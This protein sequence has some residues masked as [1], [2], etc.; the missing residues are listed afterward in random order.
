MFQQNRN[1]ITLSFTETVQSCS[2]KGGL[3]G[4]REKVHD[5][6]SLKST[7]RLFADCLTYRIIKS[8]EDRRALEQDLVWTYTEIGRSMANAIQPGQMRCSTDN[9]KNSI[10]VQVCHS[11]IGIEERQLRQ[12]SG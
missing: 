5:T 7:T 11:R 12:V 2:K 6:A 9:N 3:C 10:V 1:H 8:E 4:E